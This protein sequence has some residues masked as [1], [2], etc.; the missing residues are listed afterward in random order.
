VF[1]VVLSE[2]GP[3]G[4]FLRGG[5]WGIWWWGVFGRV[6]GGGGWGGGYLCNLPSS[7]E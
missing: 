6:V 1:V 5:G 7:F 3:V 2:E 4:V